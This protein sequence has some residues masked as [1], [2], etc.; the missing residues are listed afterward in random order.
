[1]TR[2]PDFY[3]T[4][5]TFDGDYTAQG[6]YQ[7]SPVFFQGEDVILSGYTTFEGKPVLPE[8]WNLT[9]IIKKNKYASNILWSGTINDGLTPRYNQ[10]DGYYQVWMPASVSSLFLPGTYT[11]VIQGTQKTGVSEEA[12]EITI[13]FWNREFNIELSAGSPNPQLAPATSVEIIKD[14][15]TGTTTITTTSVE[16]TVPK[17]VPTT[18]A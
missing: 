14:P 6:A 9:A 12:R 16:P 5:Q 13:H 10:V 8:D 2:L 17:S 7:L 18:Q 15:S 1:M 4:Q 11:V 3:Y